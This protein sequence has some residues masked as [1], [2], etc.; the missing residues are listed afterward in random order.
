MKRPL[1]E[2]WEATG[3]TG[4]PAVHSLQRT[5]FGITRVVTQVEGPCAVQ[6]LDFVQYRSMSFRP[7]QTLSRKIE[8]EMFHPSRRR[9]PWD[10]TDAPFPSLRVVGRPGCG[11]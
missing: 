10:R 8:I 1:P 3:D 4:G 7:H 6:E 11:S 9:A 5:S 2:Q